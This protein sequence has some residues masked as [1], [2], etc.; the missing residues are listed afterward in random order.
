MGQ[1]T[2]NHRVTLASQMKERGHKEIKC[3]LKY[4]AKVPKV[5]YILALKYCYMRKIYAI[6]VE[7]QKKEEIMCRTTH[8]PFKVG[9]RPS[10][11]ITK[12]N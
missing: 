1:L 10:A 4:Y 11:T 5:T 8:A 7:E 3:N 9:S 2:C 12:A 6:Q